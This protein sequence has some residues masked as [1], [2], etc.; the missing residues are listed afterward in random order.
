MRKRRYRIFRKKEEPIDAQ[1]PSGKNRIEPSLPDSSEISVANLAKTVK[2]NTY[3][4]KFKNLSEKGKETT[5]LENPYQFY[6]V[7]STL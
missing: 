3:E 1:E 4:H 6:L 2:D 5:P 7:Y